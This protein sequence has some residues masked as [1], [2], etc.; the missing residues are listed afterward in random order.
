LKH[1]YGESLP[2]PERV[3]PL[4]RAERGLKREKTPRLFAEHPSLR[5]PERSA[6]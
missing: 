1:S 5:S 2:P 6:D 3:A 4:T